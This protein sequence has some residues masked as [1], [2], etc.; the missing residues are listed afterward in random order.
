[1]SHTKKLPQSVK[2]FFLAPLIATISIVILSSLVTFLIRIPLSESPTK[3]MSVLFVMGIFLAYPIAVLLFLPQHLL[4]AHYQLWGYLYYCLIGLTTGLITTGAT[5][6]ILF[7]TRT[8]SSDNIISIILLLV[9]PSI[10]GALAFRYIAGDPTEQKLDKDHSKAD[11]E[12]IRY[13]E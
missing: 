2:A 10:I 1:M 6:F 7:S 5:Y 4:L 13:F 8:T 9:L 12:Y 3:F 11:K